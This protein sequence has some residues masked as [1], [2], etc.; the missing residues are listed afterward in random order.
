L[1][2]DL[3]LMIPGPTKIHPRVYEAMSR[4]IISHVSQPFAALLRE[5][6]AYTQEVM[7]TGSQIFLVAGSGT[8]A[9]EMGISNVIEP[10]DRVLALCNGHFGERYAQIVTRHGG[11]V[12]RLEVPWGR[13]IDPEEVR[14]RLEE[15]EYRA[16]TVVHVDTSTAAAN[17]IGRIGEVVKRH[18]SLYVVDSVCSLGGMEMRVDDWGIDICVSASQKALAAPPG[19]AIVAASERA[20]KVHSARRT[21]VGFFYGDFANWLPKMRD[22][23]KY[24]ATLPV[25]TIYAYREALRIIMEEGLEARFARHR[26]LASAFRSAM[27]ELGLNLVADDRCA[28]DTLT[29]LF[30]PPGID[31]LALRKHVVERHGVV[32]S[33]GL[34]GL[35]GRAMR[36]GHMGNVSAAH[37]ERTV[38]AIESGL[39]AQ[40]YR[41]LTG[42]LRAGQTHSAS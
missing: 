12:E 28:A 18:D 25:N 6:L 30:Y 26:S 20:M 3:L 24:F 42:T 31:D 13:A 23:T 36:V 11:V 21:P 37:I 40:G 15:T 16:V 2:E 5:C 32:V 8:L 1:A 22:A 10:G 17:D 41:A 27:K 38:R 19:L 4:P 35:A 34:G 14:W 39:T 33:G 29:A 7:R 9:M